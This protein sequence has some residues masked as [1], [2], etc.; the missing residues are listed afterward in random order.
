M[1]K[2]IVRP[3][4]YLKLFYC[5]TYG[6]IFHYIWCVDLPRLAFDNR[7]HRENIWSQSVIVYFRQADRDVCFVLVHLQLLI[8]PKS[9]Q[10]IRSQQ[11][12]PVSYSFLLNCFASYTAINIME[13]SRCVHL[14]PPI[15]LTWTLFR[16]LDILTR[17]E[18][19]NGNES[20]HPSLP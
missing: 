20:R 13:F 2:N 8:I 9:L 5:N 10:P 12:V 11:N 14:I 19:K 4:A 3:V 16:S 7:F 6:R 17:K 18:D 1:M 15:A